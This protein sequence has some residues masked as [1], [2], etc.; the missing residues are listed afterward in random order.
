MMAGICLPYLCYMPAMMI[1]IP[2]T[3]TC[4]CMVQFSAAVSSVSESQCTSLK[5]RL[6]S[7]SGALQ[8]QLDEVHAI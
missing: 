3:H 2:E 4:T 8:L 5:Q 1:S 6:I 7:L